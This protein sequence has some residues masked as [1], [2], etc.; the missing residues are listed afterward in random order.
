VRFSSA[1]VTPR[2]PVPEVG[3]HTE[4]VLHEFG[5]E[6]ARIEKLRELAVIP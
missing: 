5:V 2:G 6:P 1:D 4:A 3:E